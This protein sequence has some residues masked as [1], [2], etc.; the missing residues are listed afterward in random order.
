[1]AKSN[2]E[3]TIYDLIRQR[4]KWALAALVVNVVTLIILFVERNDYPGTGFPVYYLFGLAAVLLIIAA[5]QDKRN[6]K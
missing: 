4:N 3:K 1:M 2:K 6:G 5:L